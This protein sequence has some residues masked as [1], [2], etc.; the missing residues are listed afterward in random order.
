MLLHDT[1]AL[2]DTTVTV[3]THP[4]YN[5]GILVRFPL[6]GVCTIQH[7]TINH[8][9]FH[10]FLCFVRVSLQC[11]WILTT[12]Q[13]T[14]D[15]LENITLQMT[16]DKLRECKPLKKEMLNYLGRGKTDTTVSCRRHYCLMYYCHSQ[17]HCTHS[18]SI[19]LIPVKLNSSKRNKCMTYSTQ[20]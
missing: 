17:W 19:C 5:Y 7:R 4:W 1:E 12:L 10:A 6:K 9:K 8:A 13:M 14:L 16:K 18:S 20:F 15:S 11:I 3:R 2:S